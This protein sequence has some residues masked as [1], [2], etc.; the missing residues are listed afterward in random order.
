MT[1]KNEIFLGVHTYINDINFKTLIII[2]VLVYG[3]SD[4][5]GPVFIQ[6][7]PNQ[8]DFSNTTGTEIVCQARG[9]PMPHIVWVKG[10]G[11]MVKDVPGLR[12]VRDMDTVARGHFYPQRI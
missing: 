10:T 6:E 4:T 12:Q 11:E 5:S 8:V 9:T 2:F 7:P 3:E 1:G